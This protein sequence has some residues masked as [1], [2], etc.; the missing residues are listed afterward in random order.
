MKP[1]DAFFEIGV[2]GFLGP[3][4]AHFILGLV[5]QNVSNISNIIQI[6]V[7][8]STFQNTIPILLLFCLTIY[9]MEIELLDFNNGQIQ[10]LSTTFNLQKKLY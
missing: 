3:L 5:W 2:M 10:N 7:F 4:W 8:F 1:R 9:L 6:M